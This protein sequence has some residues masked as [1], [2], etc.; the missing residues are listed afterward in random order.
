MA[1][2]GNVGAFNSDGENIS[3]YCDRFDAF[4]A[5]ND[6]TNGAKK[7][8]MFLA[9]IGP[10][11][12]K[13]LKNISAP[14][15]PNTKTYEQLQDA[16]K[17][18]FDP[19]PIVIA[20]RHKFWTAYQE[21]NESV[22]D[23]VVRLKKLSTTCS[24]NTFLE[25]ALRD[26]LVSGLHKKMIK[27][28][29]QL[30]AMRD[31][32]FQVAKDKC[33]AEEMATKA[34]RG[35]MGD[36][37]EETTHKISWQGRKED[38]CKCCGGVNHK[39]ANC[40]F[41]DAVCHHCHK[42]GHIKPVCRL[43]EN[44]GKPNYRS[45][46]GKR[47]GNMG[48]H[49]VDEE[50]ASVHQEEMQCEP[51]LHD[52]SEEDVMAYGT[53][54]THRSDEKTEP[55][56]MEIG[57][58]PKKLIMELDTGATLSTV[59]ERIYKELL[60]MDYSL[61]KSHIKLH[62]YNNLPVPV[63][64]C[65]T[66]P[67]KYANNVEC[68]L[69]LLVVG[70]N[71]PALFGR[72]WIKHFKIDWNKVCYKVIAEESK[73]KVKIPI[74]EEFPKEFNDLLHQNELL[75][76]AKDTGIKEFKAS[77]KLKPNAKPV[78]QKSRPVPYSLISHVEK[79]YDKLVKAD[80]FYPVTCSQW[81]S[82]VV[83]VP[84]AQG[85][86][87]VCGDYKC[88][89]KSIMDDGYKLPNIQ[90]MF[91]KITQYGSQPKIFSVIDLASAFNQLFVDEESAKYLVVNTCKGLMGTKRLCFGI[92]TAPAQFQAV[93]D[94]ILVGI[95][96]I[97]C[98]ID[99][100]LV[101]SKSVEEHLRILKLVFG[102]LAKYN[103]RMNGDKCLFFRKKI[104]YLGHELSADG[105]R[106]L[107]GKVEAILKA[108]RPKD[109]T[110]L[111]S[112]LGM[113]NFYG[114][115]IPDL[116]SKMHPLYKLLHHSAPWIWSSECE[117]AF[118]L[119][120]QMLVG[121]NVLVHY[122]LSKPLVLCV[123]ASQHG[124]GAV[125]SHK[126]EDGSE[127]PIAYAS[128]TLSSAEGNYAQIEREGLAIIFG[129]KKFHMY[130]YG[131]KFTLVT[132]HQPLT[133]IFGPMSGIPPLAAARMQRW[134]L[135]LAGYDYDIR[136]RS[137]SDNA[138]AD[139]L[140]RLPVHDVTPVDPDENFAFSTVVDTL[141]ITS[142]M[143]AQATSTD[144]ILAKVLEFTASGW[145]NHVEDTKLVPYFR[146]RH[147]LSIEDSCVLWGR[148]VIIPATLQNQILAELHEC[149]PGMCRMKALA[150]SFVWW[151]GLDQDIEDMVRTCEVCVSNQESP[152]VVPL[153]LWPW[154]TEP[155]QRIHVDF[156][157]VKGQ[158]FLVIVDSHSKW[159][160]V[161]PM[162]VTTAMATINILRSLF[163]RY[164]LVHEV[165]S[166]NGPQFI[167]GEFKSF[168]KQLDIKHTLCPP[169]HPASNGLA[170]KHVQT[171]KR[172][173]LKYEGSHNLPEKMADILFRYRN[174]PHTTT[175]KTPAELFLKRT[176]RTIL[177]LVK[178]CLQRKVERAQSSTKFQRDGNHPK[179]RE[180][181]LFQRVRVRNIRGGKEKWIPGIVV[182]IK[183]PLTYI[184]RVPG[185][186]RRY[187][188]ADHLIPDDSKGNSE[189]SI[190]P[191]EE[192][193]TVRSES[194]EYPSRVTVPP[195][196]PQRTIPCEATGTEVSEIPVNTPTFSP[197]SPNHIHSPGSNTPTFSPRPPSQ[198]HS[199]GSSRV[200]RYGR[201]I[202]P[203]KKLD[204]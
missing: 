163:S 90:D 80:I 42:R 140:S 25:E 201:V 100:I 61:K 167:S 40:R 59:G 133:R 158:Q 197:R 177:S 12:F 66:I 76:S 6:I 120:K 193:P 37:V 75:F 82:P 124:L 111:K 2:Y 188:H 86:V 35:Y 50:N 134:A 185:N 195:V 3:D 55:Y 45:G 203:P 152:K 49:H 70:G 51:N 68:H 170:E 106:P 178:P 189:I 31:L 122:D 165:V 48:Q 166:D 128:R 204:I 126:M 104:Q 192:L 159:L 56:K 1:V 137:S 183:G 97:F 19:E 180:F 129:I 132:D 169:Y 58:G 63:L 21:E 8:N 200:S 162:K 187:V 69:D 64:G 17:N 127:K 24:F 150:R 107:Q 125:L 46:Q 52:D 184:V 147:E 33:I 73:S 172:M 98:Y 14:D 93:M 78:Y 77:I 36:C 79:E 27:A 186:N 34:S 60:A 138:V 142:K 144:L 161:F 7:V 9:T 28:Q 151:P 89:N 85:A 5:A 13:L 103:V 181:D 115:F 105:I 41:R 182:N 108:P 26:R 202:H 91:S 22:A 87:R 143:I 114:K 136:Y 74:S 194:P 139:L 71:R 15:N 67:V 113:I 94:K 102:R 101:V 121:E 92:K 155:W 191:E 179:H 47:P 23:F 20:E 199:P 148:R 38:N 54:N 112:L 110:G 156:A 168:L 131:H 62:C 81:A 10:S 141:P 149:H 29:R 65:I 96:G 84:K 164:G 146:H 16:L 130:L 99:D 171:F 44:S 175:G 196:E 32:T 18:H 83:H 116:A 95:E 57:I 88:V 109:V 123:D 39:S 154:S 30:L 198:I 117:D 135:I 145:P 176:P 174:I 118:N 11:A 4:L 157:E 153:L 119:A 190:E 173:F 72:N 160:E 43:R 53:Y